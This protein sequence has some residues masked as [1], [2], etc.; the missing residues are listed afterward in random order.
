VIVTSVLGI[1][2]GCADQ[3][4]QRSAEQQAFH[5]NLHPLSS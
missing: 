2:C 3:G 1:E 4:N 5:P